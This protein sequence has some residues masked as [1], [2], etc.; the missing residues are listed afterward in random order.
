VPVGRRENVLKL[1]HNSV[2]GAHMGE[3]KTSQ[4]IKLSFYWLDLKK[5]VRQYTASCKDCQL[6][7]RILAT[8]RVPIT[9]IT[10][11]EVPFQNLNM[12]W[13]PP[14]TPTTLVV[15]TDA[16][17]DQVAESHGT[18]SFYMFG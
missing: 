15:Q 9:P 5:S 12:D 1:G 18:A 4:R 2:F 16:I 17:C 14:A 13:G 10:R 3:R 6:R 8:D 7:S 11:D